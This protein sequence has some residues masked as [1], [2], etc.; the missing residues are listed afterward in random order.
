MIIKNQ[1]VTLNLYKFVL[2]NGFCD[3]FYSH[4][5]KSFI[6]KTAVDNKQTKIPVFFTILCHISRISEINVT[7]KLE[8]KVHP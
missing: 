4:A 1:N 7:L 2:K 6:K 5:I 3:I 8:Y